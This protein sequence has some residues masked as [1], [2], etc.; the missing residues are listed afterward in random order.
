MIH[1]N[2]RGVNPQN[3]RNTTNERI[4][5]LDMTRNHDR[6]AVRAICRVRVDQI[7]INDVKVIAPPL[8]SR[9]FVAMPTRKYGDEW[10]PLVVFV[11]PTLEQAISDAV[12]SAWRGVRE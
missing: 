2:E 11:S 8:A 7:I 9:A 5:I 4:E 3:S 6:S 12:L 10:R 1:Q